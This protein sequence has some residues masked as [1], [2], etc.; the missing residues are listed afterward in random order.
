MRLNGKV[1]LIT[2][3][4]SGIG[5]ATAILFAKEGAKVSVVDVKSA[6]GQETVKMITRNKG[7]AQFIIADVSK[8]ADVER[9]I[10]MTV[11]SYGRLDILFNNAGIAPV[12]RPI[13]ETDEAYWDRIIDVNL[14]SIF[15][16]CKYAVPVMKKQGGGVIISTSSTSAEYPA[17]L[18]A[19]YAASKGGVVA[20][21][22]S[23]ALELGPHKIRAN[24]ISPWAVHTPMWDEIGGETIDQAILQITPLGRLC[25]PEEVAYAALYLASDEAAYTSGLNMYVDGAANSGI[26][27]G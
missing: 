22:K 8:A 24:C 1:A 14:K 11:D 13:E 26:F 7:V 15:L 5:R 20:F 19:P 21:T 3:G 25:K 4:G 9:A 6:D 27:L 12:L 10:K 23:M 18:Q 2:G 17:A 16:G